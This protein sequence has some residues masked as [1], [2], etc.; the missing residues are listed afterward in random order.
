MV[1]ERRGIGQGP[2]RETELLGVTGIYDRGLK[3]A[4]GGGLP[5]A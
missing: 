1:L 3:C 4:V 2:I 5:S